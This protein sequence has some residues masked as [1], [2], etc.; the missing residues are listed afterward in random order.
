MELGWIISGPRE[1]HVQR[2]IL[3]AILALAPRAR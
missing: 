1:L 2:Q 3:R